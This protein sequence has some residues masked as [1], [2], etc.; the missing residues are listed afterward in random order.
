VSLNSLP[1][2][3][4]IITAN[5]VELRIRKK[6]ERIAGFLTQLTRFFRR[7]DA[8]GDGTNANLAELIQVLLNAP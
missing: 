4:Q 5:R 6:G 8:D 2:V 7:I 3:H 1:S